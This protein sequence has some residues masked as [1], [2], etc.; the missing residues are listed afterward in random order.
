VRAR[1]PSLR[2]VAEMVREANEAWDGGEFATLVHYTRLNGGHGAWAVEPVSFGSHDVNAPPAYG[3]EWLP[4]DGLPCDAVA[5]ARRLLAAW[6][7]A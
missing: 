4:G 5:V 7:D 1:L 2:A 3:R 6:R